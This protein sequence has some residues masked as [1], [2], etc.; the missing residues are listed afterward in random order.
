MRINCP[1][2]GFRD[3]R[4][5]AYLGDASVARPDPDAPNALQQFVTYVYV[6][7]N[8]AGPHKEFWYH[9]SGC[10]SWLVVTRDTRTHQVMSVAYPGREEKR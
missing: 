9:K 7:A 4:E 3:V 6:R 10:Q 2:C 8:P 1:H 5:F